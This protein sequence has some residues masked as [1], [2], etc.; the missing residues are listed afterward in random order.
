MDAQVIYGVNPVVEALCAGATI[1]AIH[2][3]IGL[4]KAT[5]AR[6]EQLAAPRG[7]QVLKTDR[8][9]LDRMAHGGSHQGVV[10]VARKPGLVDLDALAG[11]AG[12]PR[13]LLLCLDGIQDPHNLGALARSARA[14]GATGLVIC[15]RRAAGLSPAAL[16]SSAGALAHLPVAR[17]NNMARALEKLKERGFWVSGA[18]V[19]DGQAPWTYDPGEKVALVLGSEGSGPRRGVQ[20]VFDHR[21]RIP[22]AAEGS[23][24]VS[25]A[26]GLLLYEWLVRAENN[27]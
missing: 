13:T 17:V 9:E 24:N 21:V 10:A 20:E 25:V 27:D 12:K 14:C 22:M 18:V 19:D 16:K 4:R 2:V 6:I 3:A 23:L 15:A 8:R 26:G 7:I 1:E 5:R 11:R